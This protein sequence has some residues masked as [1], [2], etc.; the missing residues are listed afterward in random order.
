M[1]GS[2]REPPQPQVPVTWPA[3]TLNR[4]DVPGIVLKTNASQELGDFARG[5]AMRWAICASFFGQ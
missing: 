2:S 3:V 5:E 4:V 1:G